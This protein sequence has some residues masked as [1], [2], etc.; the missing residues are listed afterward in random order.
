MTPLAADLCF[1]HRKSYQYTLA[2]R[3]ITLT[4]DKSHY[5]QFEKVFGIETL[6]C[7]HPSL[8][9]TR[10]KEQEPSSLFTGAKVR[11][12][13][14]CLAC[15]KPR[16]IYI[17]KQSTYTQNTVMLTFAVE[18]NHYV[19]GSPIFP[20]GHP[21]TGELHIRTSLTCKSPIERRPSNCLR[22][23]LTVVIRIVMFHKH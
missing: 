19:C 15:D 21:L 6:E 20:E 5:K 18:N 8:P 2:T 13:V 9:V 10:E 1:C 12:V 14:E 4:V 23:V 7:D 16:C 11:D 17:D 22:Y 3:S